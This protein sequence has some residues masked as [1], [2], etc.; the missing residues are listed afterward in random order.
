M[1]QSLTS[2]FTYLCMNSCS[3]WGYFEPGVF[4][5][6]GH[7]KLHDLHSILHDQ[8]IVTALVTSLLTVHDQ[9]FNCASLALREGVYFG[10]QLRH[11]KLL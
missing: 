7:A 1:T 9:L 4:Q 11:R 2:Q 8:S 3:A 10:L 6:Q 5:I